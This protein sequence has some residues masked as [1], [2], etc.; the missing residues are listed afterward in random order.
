MSSITAQQAKLDLELMPKEKGFEIGKY[1]G[2]LNPGK[3]QREP[4]FQVILDALALTPY[5]SAFLTLQIVHGQDFDELP[6]DEVI[7]SFFKELGHTWEIKSI[8]DV[9][10][11]Q[12]HQPWRTFAT[13]INRSLSE[14]TTG[15]DKLRLSRAQ[16]LWGMYYKKNVDYVELLWEDFAYQINNRAHKK[17]ERFT[18]VII[19]YFLTKD[20]TVSWRNKIGMHTS[21][22]DYL[23]NTLRFVSTNETYLGYAIGVTPPKIARKFKKAS[24]SKKDINLTLVLVDEE[25]KSAKKKVP[26][27]KTT[28]KQSSGVVLRDTHMVSLSKKKEKVFVDKGKGIELLSE[29]NEEEVEDDEEEKEDEF[30]K[31]P[32]NYTPTDDE[33]E[34]NVESKVKDNVEGDEDKRIDYTTNQFDD[35]LDIRLNDPVHADEGLVQKEGTNA[36]MISVHQGNENLEIILDQVI[37][38]AYVTISIVAKKTE[39]PSSQTPILLTVPI[40]V[41]TESLH[42]YTTVIPQS[43]PSFTP[44]PPLSTPIPPPITEAT[45]PLSALLDFASVFQFNNRVSALEKEVSELRKDDLLKTQ[46]SSQPSP[47]YEAAASLIEFKL[48][49][50]LI[51]K[52]EKSQS[53]LTATPH[54]ECCD[55]LIKSYDLDKSLFSTYD[56][57]CSLKRNREDKDKD[58]DP[59]DGSDQRLKKKKTSKDVK[60]TKEEPEF[61]VADSDMPQNHKGNL[62]NDDEELIREDASEH[63]WFPKPKQPQE[64]TDPDWN[65]GKTPQQEP[66]QS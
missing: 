62:G 24:S 22:D 21:R 38:D 26:A 17:Q 54:K 65:V 64:P 10:V 34:T 42:V 37:E 8:T 9:V 31:A 11:D 51:E 25:P 35:D 53:Y 43:L 16:I 44:T 28:R 47:T 18:K 33:D 56:K 14:K 61:E 15:P 41:I 20:K 66:T 12:I 19:H 39:V 1:N 40:T 57:V 50:I 45:N 63:D 60:P 29:E 55:G 13:I 48:K 4:T 7:M 23:K 2:R 59:S 32:S 36:E 6:T 30:V 49:K 58:E 5:Y 3:T 27:M 46:K 52:M